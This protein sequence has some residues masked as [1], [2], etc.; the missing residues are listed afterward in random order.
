MPFQG[1]LAAREP[2]PTSIKEPKSY[3]DAVS[4]PMFGSQWEKAIEEEKQNLLSHGTWEFVDAGEIPR[5]RKPTGCRWVFK[6]KHHPN[7]LPSRFKARLVAQGFS[8]TYGI[9]FTE[10]YAPTLRLN[11]LRLLLALCAIHDWELHQLDIVG[12]Y[13]EETWMRRPT[14]CACQKALRHQEKFAGC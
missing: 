3:S 13:L 12:A 9:D 8:Q 5:A 6:V 11:S 10:T 1:D 4:D 14:T 7:G 2:F